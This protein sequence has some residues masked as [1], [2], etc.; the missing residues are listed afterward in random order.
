MDCGIVSTLNG[1]IVKEVIRYGVKTGPDEGATEVH[2][3]GLHLECKESLCNES[4]A[5]I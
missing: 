4:F 2:R 1:D 5:C 3:E